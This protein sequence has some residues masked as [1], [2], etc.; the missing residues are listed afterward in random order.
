LK[1]E[2]SYIVFTDF[3][4]TITQHDIGDK[5]FQK[6]GDVELCEK[7]FH[8]Y[9]SGEIDARD[10]WRRSCETVPNVTENVFTDFAKEQLID[11]TFPAFVQYCE[12]Q[13]IPVVVLSDGFDAYINPVLDS[14]GF[15]HLKRFCNTLIFENG[16][17]RPEFP[18]TDE[19]CRQCANCKR[20]HMLTNSGEEHVIVYIGDGY[21]DRCPSRYADIVFA[22]KSLVPYCETNNITFHRFTSFSD[23]LSKFKAIVETSKP[24]KKTMAEHARKEIYLQ[25]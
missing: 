20:N 17:I 12:V 23:V 3:D 10:C 15:S 2:L 25:G 14:N 22:K 9:T 8:Y 21:S 13:K 24:K 11:P 1:Q 4:G 16:K 18:F 5:M 6:F 19:N 7:H